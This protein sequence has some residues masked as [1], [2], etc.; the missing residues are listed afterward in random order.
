M[1][2]LSH[3]YSQ[4]YFYFILFHIQRI[5]ISVHIVAHSHTHTGKGGKRE[6]KV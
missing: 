2:G 6:R 1:E 5:P 4:Q 3:W